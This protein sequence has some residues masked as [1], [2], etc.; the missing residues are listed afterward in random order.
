MDNERLPK[1][2]L[3]AQLGRERPVGRSRTSW[4]RVI[5]TDL[6]AIECDNYPTMVLDHKLWRKRIKGPYTAQAEVAPTQRSLR[7][8]VKSQK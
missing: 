8:S 5:R 6:E 1:K 4:W 7:L 2:M 3:T